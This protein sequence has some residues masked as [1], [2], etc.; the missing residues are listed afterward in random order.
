M[1]ERL[2]AD[3]D[4]AAAKGTMALDAW[5]DL[6]TNDEAGLVSPSM[7]RQWRETAEKAAT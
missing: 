7:E 1:Q 3:G 5:M 6:L 4:A 2:Q